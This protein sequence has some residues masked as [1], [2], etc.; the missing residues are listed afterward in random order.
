[1]AAVEP[2]VV[3]LS[4]PKITPSLNLIAMLEK[5]QTIQS[6]GKYIDVPRSISPFFNAAMSTS[7]GLW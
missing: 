2:V 3:L 4:A 1:M 7:R 5:G 6:L